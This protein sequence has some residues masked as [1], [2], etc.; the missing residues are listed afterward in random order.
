MGNDNYKDEVFVSIDIEADGPSPGPNSMLSF[1]AVAQDI[2]RN[3]LGEFERNLNV[4]ENSQQDK[5]TMTEFWANFPEMYQATRQDMVH[6]HQAME[7]FKKWVN[8]LRKHGVP[9]FV[10]YPLGFDYKYMDWYM[11]KFLGKNVFG[12]SGI[13][14]K[15]FAM[16]MLGTKFKET[17]KGIFPKRWFPKN[18]PHT[19]LAIDDAREQCHLFIS[20][21]RENRGLPL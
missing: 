8:G 21:I 15:S 16:A 3:N 12:I 14:I 4:L 11:H 10:A 17:N 19:H 7:E 5:K 2:N 9:I 20:I 6:P 1:A 13:D 18:M